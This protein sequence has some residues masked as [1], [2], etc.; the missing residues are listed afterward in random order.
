MTFPLYV[1]IAY[2]ALQERDVNVFYFLEQEYNYDAYRHPMPDEMTALEFYIRDDF[3][4]RL[5]RHCGE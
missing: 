5:R 3:F 1:E 4:D 2:K